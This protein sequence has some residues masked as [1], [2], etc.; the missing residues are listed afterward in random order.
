MKTIEEKAKAHDEALER[1]RQIAKQGGASRYLV[2][3]IFP[4]LAENED[5]RIRK[6]IMGLT[7]IDGIEPILTKCS[8]TA[9]DI[10][11]YLEKQKD[12][13]SKY[14]GMIVVS[15]E[16]WNSAIADAFKHGM[17]EGKKQKK[18][19][20]VIND[21]QQECPYK[22]L[23]LVK[24]FFG[25]YKR[26]C[27][28]S[29]KACDSKKCKQW[30]ELQSEFKNINEAFE[31]GK[32]EVIA[33]PEKYGL[34]KEQKAAESCST[35]VESEYD[36][37][38]KE[39]VK[40][41]LEKTWHYTIGNTFM[42]LIPCWVNAPSELQSAH[43]Y[44]GKNAVIMH[45]NNGGF[46]CCFIDDKEATTVG[47]PED[48]SFVEGW[49]KKPAEWNVD[50]YS[51]PQEQ[52]IKVYRV[53]NEKE[54]K[55]LWRK[56]DGTWE[57]LFDMLTDGQCKDMPMEDNPI[58]REGGKQWFA[59]A[60]SK[61]T[62]Q[63]W[64][65]K[66]DLEELTTKGFTISEFEVVGHKKVSDFEY[67]FTRDSIISRTYLKVSDIYPQEQPEM[68]LEKDVESWFFNEISSKI[69]VEHTMYHY[70]KECARRY[71]ERGKNSKCI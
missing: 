58:Y 70:F 10:R 50:I 62:L 63:K 9:Q 23:V 17:D 26:K 7:Y 32:N 24:N 19:K 57:P 51:L 4:Q 27:Q 52:P 40:Y 38:Y 35:C 2:T 43:K 18:Q 28:L 11:K 31:D 34:Q 69:N 29:N 30:N 61:E 41:A 56:F 36:K 25:E 59:S 1:A 45:E 15:Q 71:F 37:G 21:E 60:P 48:T 67:I 68:D 46:R 49:R 14:A 64:F 3:Q 55:G 5:E 47:L 66:K 33:N 53:E 22:D 42:G 44:H 8:I 65:S 12:A 6:A 39:G 54:Q 20:P 16:E 13:K